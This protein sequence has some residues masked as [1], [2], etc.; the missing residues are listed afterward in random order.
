[1]R[2]LGSKTNDMNTLL[3]EPREATEA[4]PTP[5][6]RNPSPRILVVDDANYI[7]Q[8]MASFLTRFG[9]QVDT[10]EDG[11]AGWNALQAN[12]YDLLLTDNNMPRLSGLDLIK[13]LRFARMNLPVILVSGAMS[14]DELDQNPA[15]QLAAT[16]PKP[17]S[18]D[19]LLETVKAALCV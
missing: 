5:G 18:P 2:G 8:L 14:T 15:L 3:S 17:F 1:M 9:Y 6:R 16:L 7:R 13:R 4:A 10:A 19:E 11:A 12:H